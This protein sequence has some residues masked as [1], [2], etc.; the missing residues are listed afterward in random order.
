MVLQTSCRCLRE[1]TSGNDESA[2]IWLNA[3][4]A[5]VLDK[6]LQEE[7]KTSIEEINRKK[8][9]TNSPIRNPLSRLEHLHLPKLSFFQLQVRF[10]TET[11]SDKPEPKKHLQELLGMLDSHP[12]RNTAVVTTRLLGS[13]TLSKEILP[14][15]G[16]ESADWEDWIHKLVVGSCGS[17]TRSAL[18]A[19]TSLLES[20]FQKI[21]RDYEEKMERSSQTIY[22]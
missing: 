17:L 3:E 21:T 20:I 6:Q 11:K 9:H 2:V 8:T 15:S 5:K 4:N 13:K 7:Q 1:V 10:D 16:E 14:Y 12:Y 18:L 19:E 22:Y